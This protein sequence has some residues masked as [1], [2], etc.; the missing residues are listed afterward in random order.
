MSTSDSRVVDALHEGQNL[1]RVLEALGCDTRKDNG[2]AFE[3]PSGFISCPMPDHPDRNPSCTVRA[4]MGQLHC[5]SLCENILPADLVVAHGVASDRAEAMK[6]IERTLGI[7]PVRIAPVPV[8][9]DPSLTV[10]AYLA[11]KGLPPET[12]TKFGLQTVRI[13]QP[14]ADKGTAHASYETGWYDAVFMP[15]REGRRPRVRSDAPGRA[16][17][18][19]APKV[20]FAD[21]TMIDFTNDDADPSRF[22]YPLDVIGMDQLEPTQD[23]VPNVL[24]VVEGE[25]DVHAMHAMQLPGVVGVPG[26]KM[27]GRVSLP[28]LEACIVA[29]EGDTDL[30]SL[31]VLVWQEPG[32]AGAQFPK[33]VADA[34]GEA[35]LQHAYPAPVFGVLHYG[36]V[37]GQ[38]KDPAALLQD[39]PLADAREHL[40]ASILAALPQVGSAAAIAGSVPAPPP[41]ANIAPALDPAQV[42]GLHT[43]PPLTVDTILAGAAPDPV[44]EGELPAELGP[45]WSAESQAPVGRVLPGM[46]AATEPVVVHRGPQAGV[47]W[48]A[49]DE[50][51]DPPARD[52]APERV[53]GISSNFIRT[54]EGWSVEKIDKDGDATLVAICTAFVVEQVERCSGEILVR[55][56]APFGGAWNRTRLAMS[57]TADAG[58]TC[59]QLAA[60]GVATVN[61]QRPAVTDLLLALAMRCEAELGAVSVPSGTGWSGRPGSSEFGGIEV[62]PVN[63]F[64]ARMF[65]ANERRRA[66]RP[67]TREAALEWLEVASAL[68]A[69]PPGIEE[70]AASHAAPMLAIG[71]AAAAVLV[72]PLAEVGV[73]VSPVVWIA[74][75]GGGGKSVTQKLAA[76]IFAPALPD[77]DGQSAYFAN[78]NIS[79]AALSARVDS[80]RDLPLILDDVTQL[81]PLPGST[82]RG[83]AARIE[84]AAALGMMVFNRKP[85]ERATRDGGIRQ[86]KAFRSTAIFSAEVS[87]SSESSKAVVTAGHRRRIS[88]IEAR[89]M[90]ERGLAQEYAERVNYAAQAVGG[91][92]GELL[93][94]RV[95]EIVAAR[96]L[97]NLYDG[98]RRRVAAMP[99]ARDVTMTQIESLAVTLLGLALLIEAI[100]EDAARSTI[101]DGLLMLGPYLAAGAGA[102]GAT[103]DTDLSGVEA[104][105]RS[106]DDLRASHPTRFDNQ[107]RDEAGLVVPPPTAG[108]L[109]KELRPRRDGTRQ[110][111]MLRTGMEMLNTRYGVTMQVIEQAISDGVLVRKQVRMSDDSRPYAM[112]WMLP[113]R[114][115][116]EPDDDPEPDFPH[117]PHG[118]REGVH[119]PGASVAHNVEPNEPPSLDEYLDQVARRVAGRFERPLQSTEGPNMD[120]RFSFGSGLY[121]VGDGPSM[122][123]NVSHLK[124]IRMEARQEL[125]ALQMLYRHAAEKNPEYV[126]DVPGFPADDD[127]RWAKID[128]LGPEVARAQWNVMNEHLWARNQQEDLQLKRTHD[129]AYVKALR[130]HLMCRYRHPEWFVQ[131]TDKP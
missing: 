51:E 115:E 93:V 40:E 42:G 123:E 92:P 129:E 62:E 63:D 111:A 69:P 43:P 7:E 127:P 99:E 110:I 16:Q 88:T 8:V 105:L 125:E 53:E 11:R 116:L 81:P 21:G 65:E 78:A 22:R 71:A 44:V 23:G 45:G 109:G 70:S 64:G 34:I 28:L 106:V 39:R 118:L 130:V 19:W 46:V 26:A 117:D 32:S 107:V 47:L 97:R 72:G 55:V 31:T 79:Q 41:P 112:V 15:T 35:A 37:P 82:S 75:L 25:S 103:R 48:S 14:G 49:F 60:V 108:Y 131:G 100:D 114:A 83:D 77:L 59:G 12:A 38:P 10:E 67:D 94:R 13:W 61:R 96:E 126:I 33:R 4:S 85:I 74:G 73:A 98:V 24:V 86:T 20:R 3:S 113:P 6:W 58:R 5:H 122:R 1:E 68:L 36:Q 87:M 76:S 56:A 66:L 120:S 104:A 18:K 128:A 124:L 29:N 95:R 50:L 9:D 102:G 121:L 84:A 57:S 89:P 30:R 90:T 27:S 119:V 80:C 91:A 101:A 54:D 2:S 52:L 17:L